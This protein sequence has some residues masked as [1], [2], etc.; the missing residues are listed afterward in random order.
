MMNQLMAEISNDKG[1]KVEAKRSI[2]IN[3]PQTNTLHSREEE[4]EIA[5]MMA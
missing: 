4:D 5:K 3:I 1:M 2:H